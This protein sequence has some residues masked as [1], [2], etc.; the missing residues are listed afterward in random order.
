M[1]NNMQSLGESNMN[2]EMANIAKNHR[3]IWEISDR[4]TEMENIMPGF[5]NQSPSNNG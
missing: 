1:L 5:I 2:R 3:E 4:V